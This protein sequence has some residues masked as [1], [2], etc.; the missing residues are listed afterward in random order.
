[1]INL[2]FL[3]QCF[4]PAFSPAILSPATLSQVL[5]SQA[6]LHLTDVNLPFTWAIALVVGSIAMAIFKQRCDR[7]ENALRQREQEFRALAENSPDIIVQTDEDFRILYI[8]PRIEQEIGISP[9][10]LIGKTIQELGFFESQ[11]NLW[12]SIVQQVFETGQEQTMEFEFLSSQGLKYWFSRVVPEFALPK[13]A[14]SA[15]SDRRVKSVLTITRDITML[16]QAEQEV[17]DLH[18]AMEYAIEGISRIDLEGRYVTANRQYAR[19]IGYPLEEMLGMNWQQTVYP[20]DLEKVMVAYQHMLDRGSVEEEVRGLRKDGSVF[21]KRLSMV[22]ASDAQNRRIGH[23]CFMKDITAAKQAEEDLRISRARLQFLLSSTPAVIYTCEAFGCYRATFISDNVE[24]IL[25]YKPQDFYQDFR[26]WINHIHPD[27]GATLLANLSPL[28]VAGHHT[29]E[30][31]F[32]HKD[33][34]YRWMRDALKLIRDERGNPLEMV[35]YWIDITTRKQAELALQDLN[36]QLE[37]R[38]QERTAALEQTNQHLQVE[39]SERQA[40]ETALRQSESRFQRLVANVPGMIYQYVLNPDSSAEFTY[41]SSASTEIY[42]I[43]PAAI[44]QNETVLWAMVHPDDV[45]PLSAMI[46]LSAATGQPFEHVHRITTPSGRLKWLQ[47]IA[48]P[49]QQIDGKVVWDGVI[50]DISDRK[51][52]EQLKDE[53]ISLVSHEL[54]TPLTSIRTSL[55]LLAS[56]LLSHQP[57]QSQNMLDI[58]LESTN[59]LVRLVSNILDLERLQ[60]GSLDSDKGAIAQQRCN[61]ADLMMQ[62][63]NGIQPM[64]DKNHINLSITPLSVQIWADPDRMIQA[65]TNLLDNAI[66]FSSAKSTVFFTAELKPTEVLFGIKDQGRGIPADKLGVIFERFQQIDSSDSRLYGGS[67]LGLAI[68]RSIVEQHGGRIW[69]ESELGKGSHFYFTLPFEAAPA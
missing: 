14:V 37:F 12:Y 34:S 55:G 38:V 30:Y 15:M 60:S 41:A 48:R 53:L 40:T 19:I 59:R 21:Y 18:R 2:T 8:N 49:E 68:C 23:Y 11:S 66:K 46:D 52:V 5:L 64:A 17:E 20:E 16:K 4:E 45:E 44:Q 65:F 61:V 54:R 35:G 63:A 42:E 28:F 26:F 13:L 62:A 47:V 29:H 10:H 22:I 51:A 3:G 6:A 31:R 56:G 36:N 1:M 58:A 9:D 67:G 43:E 50:I 33:G 32:L 39:I 25:G 27:E 7:I 57:E 24:A 69:V